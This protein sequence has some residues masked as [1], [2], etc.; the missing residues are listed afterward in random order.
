MAVEKAALVAETTETTTTASEPIAKT[1]GLEVVV[2]TAP[3]PTPTPKI[4]PTP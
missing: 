2:Y 3:Q 4:K 1:T